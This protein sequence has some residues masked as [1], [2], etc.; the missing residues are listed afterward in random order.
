VVKY[1]RSKQNQEKEEQKWKRRKEDVTFLTFCFLVFF[2]V[3][4]N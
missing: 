3:I 4:I 1:G 2:T